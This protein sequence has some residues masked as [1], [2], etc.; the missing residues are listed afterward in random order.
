MTTIKSP[1]WPGILLLI[2]VFQLIA[3]AQVCVLPDGN[4]ELT[5]NPNLAGLFAGYILLEWLYHILAGL[6]FRAK[7]FEVELIAFFLS[8]IGLAVIAS[9]QPDLA[10]KQFFAV[11]IGLAAFLA[12]LF[13]IKN[14]DFAMKL[15]WP[16]AVF[17][18]A[19][20]AGTR[21]LAQN[22]N[23][24]YS[25]IE[26]GSFSIQPSEFVKVAFVLIGAATLDK[27]QAAR[28]LTKFIA[29]ACACVGLL[30]LMKDLGTALIFFFTFVVLSYLRS[31]DIRTIILVCVVAAMGAALVVFLRSD[32]VMNRFSAYR[33][34]WEHADDTGYQQTRVLI[35]MASG[36][37]FGTGIGQGRLKYIFAATDDLVFGLLCEEWGLAL[38]LLLLSCFAVLMVYTIR[39]APRA[40]SAFY[41]IAACSAM[42]LL[43]FQLSL[44]VFGITDLLPLTGVT[45]PFVSKGGSSMISCWALLA[46]V[47]ASDPR[48]YKRKKVLQ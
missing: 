36:G 12:V 25:W 29:F 44:N 18:I 20:L 10:L 11:V 46:F 37:L 39:M 35:A 32:Y 26:I 23:G 15:R 16:A 5:V 30:F 7:S 3:F 9:A 8:G 34:V 4:G 48:T 22:V 2:T 6:V 28:S 21:L 13:L 31:G 14:P 27:L 17:A 47:K 45:F 33:H 43:L 19:L 41:A 1:P 38:G 24:A 40:H 42:A